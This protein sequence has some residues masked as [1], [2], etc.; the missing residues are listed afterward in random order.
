MPMLPPGYV[1]DWVR[2]R[3]YATTLREVSRF[4]DL[5]S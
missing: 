5:R 3:L 4:G 1:L 2:G